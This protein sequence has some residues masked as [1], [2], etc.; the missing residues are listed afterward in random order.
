MQGQHLGAVLRVLWTQYHA[1]RRKETGGLQIRASQA[2]SIRSRQQTCK[3]SWGSASMTGRWTPALQT[4]E[5]K[6]C[7]RWQRTRAIP[8]RLS[9]IMAVQHMNNMHTLF[10]CCADTS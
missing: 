9:A 8:K 6:D 7:Q 10:N 5:C 4:F 3:Q 1:G 2:R